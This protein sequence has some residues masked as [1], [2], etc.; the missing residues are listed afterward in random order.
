MSSDQTRKTHWP[1]MARGD[2]RTIQLTRKGE[3]MA[4]AIQLSRVAK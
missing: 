1:P 4:R 3:G 2:S